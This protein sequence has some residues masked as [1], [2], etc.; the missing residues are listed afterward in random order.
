MKI[1]YMPAI[2]LVITQVS[3]SVGG[4]LIEVSMV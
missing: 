3:R 1:K 2:L 4:A